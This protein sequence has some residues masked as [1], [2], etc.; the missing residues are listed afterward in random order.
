M[1]TY[2]TSA[3]GRARPLS[4]V[5]GSHPWLVKLPAP[6]WGPHNQNPVLYLPPSIC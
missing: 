6:G 3:Y 2:P 5:F 4:D 1:K